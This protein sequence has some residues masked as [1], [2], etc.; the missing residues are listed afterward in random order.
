LYLCTKNRV[1][2][3]KSASADVPPG[4]AKKTVAWWRRLKRNTFVVS[5]NS[6]LTDRRPGTAGTAGTADNRGSADTAGTAGTA[7]SRPDR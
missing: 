5:F 1:L 2:G 3:A 6:V 4:T 7:G